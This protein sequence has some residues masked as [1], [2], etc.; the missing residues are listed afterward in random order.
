MQKLIDKLKAQGLVGGQLAAFANSD[1]VAE[2]AHLTSLDEQDLQFAIMLSLG[3]VSRPKLTAAEWWEA[4]QCMQR[5]ALGILRAPGSMADR[6]HATRFIMEFVPHAA[7]QIAIIGD[8]STDGTAMAGLEETA[9]QDGE[10]IVLAPSLLVGDQPIEQDEAF[11]LRALTSEAGFKG[12]YDWYFSNIETISFNPFGGVMP[13]AFDHENE[14]HVYGANRLLAIM[15]PMFVEQLTAFFKAYQEEIK[16][17]T[18][19]FQIHS[20]Y[21][22]LS[23]LVLLIDMF[24]LQNILDYERDHDGDVAILLAGEEEEE[25]K[26]ELRKFKLEGGAKAIHQFFMEVLS[27]DDNVNQPWVKLPNDPESSEEKQ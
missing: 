16:N 20:V 3:M 25:S 14:H 10:K 12:K 22:A 5:V 18:G 21:H 6:R 24:Q 15:L 19:F 23:N 17:N 7:V 1:S 4:I 27:N 8:R 13:V 11:D 9:T 2:Q 26:P